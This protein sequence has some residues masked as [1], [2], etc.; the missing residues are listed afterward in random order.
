MGELDGIEM[1]KCVNPFRTQGRVSA[2]DGFGTCVKPGVKDDV[3]FDIH[4]MLDPS[5]EIV[6]SKSRRPLT[7][8]SVHETSTDFT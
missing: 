8:R 4:G 6:N 1:V 7:L 5:C 3:V 2:R